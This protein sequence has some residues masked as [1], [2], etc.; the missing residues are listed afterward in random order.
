MEE[1]KNDPQMT[2]LDWIELNEEIDSFKNYETFWEK[3]K[4]R[5]L[6]NPIAPIGFRFDFVFRFVLILFNSLQ[7]CS[8]LVDFLALAFEN[9]KGATQRIS[10]L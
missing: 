10:S 9:F 3:A 7:V 6:A 2:E 4:R 8:P 1:S 5:T